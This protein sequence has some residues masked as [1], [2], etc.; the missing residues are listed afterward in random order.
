MNLNVIYG[1]PDDGTLDPAQVAALIKLNPST[2]TATAD[3]LPSGTANGAGPASRASR[4]PADETV[5]GVH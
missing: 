5:A 2:E 3:S 1:E 4:D